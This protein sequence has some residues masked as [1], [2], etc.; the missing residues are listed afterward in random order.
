MKKSFTVFFCLLLSF[1]F[2]GGTKETKSEAIKVAYSIP[3]LSAP[4]WTAASQGFLAKAAEYGL[5]AEI[6]DP[7]DNLENQIS[8]IDNAMLKGLKGLAITPI[9]GQAVSTLMN[10]AQAQKIPVIAIDR[11]VAGYSL[12]TVEA[13][14][15]LIGKLL[16]EKY[17]KTIGNKDGRVLIVGG[18]LSSSATVNRTEGFK[19]A[20]KNAKNV[21]VVAESATEMDAE[22]V[23]GAVTNYLQ[24][25]PDINAIFSCTDYILPSV[26]TAL[27][28][29]G[30]LFPIDD[31]KHV[32]VYSVDGD[33]YGLDQVL[34]GNIDATYGLDPYAWAASAVQ[35]IKDNLDGKSVQ[36][37]ILILGNIV[38]KENLKSLKEKGALWGASSMEN[39]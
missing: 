28:E 32:N 5:S 11:Q 2:A 30:K 23:L 25:N 33:G 26:M 18:P 36:K 31:P 13:D 22:V 1:A 19:A 7:N 8:Q 16:G 20:I 14:N 24:A 6:L 39:K 3:G 21:K 12:A 38:T 37:N 34:V 35:A 4:I 17:L 27:A 10:K 29:K 15:L 9:D